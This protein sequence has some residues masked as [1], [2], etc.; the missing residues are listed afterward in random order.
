MLGVDINYISVF[1][2]A[3]A[4]IIIG[5]LWYSS[6]LFGKAWIKLVGFSEK[7]VQSA[8]QQGMGKTM[9]GFFVSA[10]ITAYVLSL[11]IAI[12]GTT[13]LDEAIK[14]GFWTWLGFIA[15]IRFSDVIFAKKPLNLYY[16]DAGYNLVGII[17]MSIILTFVV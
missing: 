11:F 12:S 6:V 4:Y 1:I 13:K 5:S 16:I 10:L 8:K 3:V 15:A 14:I 7:E 2:A 9:V 17:V